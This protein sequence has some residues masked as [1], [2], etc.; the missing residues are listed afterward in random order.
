VSFGGIRRFSTRNGVSKSSADTRKNIQAAA[1][2]ILE[3][4]RDGYVHTFE[5]D[6]QSFFPSINKARLLTKL[7][8]VLKDN[9]LLDL[10]DWAISTEVSN[11][12]ELDSRGLSECWDPRVGVPQ[13]GVL[14]PLLANLYLAD[15]DKS[16]LDDGFQ[17]V[18]Y[19]DDLVILTRTASEAMRAYLAC[20]TRLAAIGLSIHEL[21]QPNEKKRIKTQILPANNS[22]DFLGLRLNSN[23]VHPAATKLE[24][25]KDRIR[26]ITHARLG[27]ETLFEVLSRLNWLLR[28]WAAAYVFC[29]IPA[30]LLREIDHAANQGLT[31]WMVYHNIVRDQNALSAE[32]RKRVGLWS[33]C[34]ME[35]RPIS[36]QLEGAT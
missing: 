3:L 30:Q 12:D 34:D 16:L 1:R 2:R 29:D 23:S 25:L 35:I 28:G 26:H 33:I 14:S 13:G 11:S 36:R 8:N 20:K 31:S 7:A 6:I 4:R 10:L 18:R 21:D 5:T 24:D 19:F 32:A 27:G 22:F 17:L 15:F 9:T